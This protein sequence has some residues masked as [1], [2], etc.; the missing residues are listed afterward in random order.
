MPARR[1]RSASARAYNSYTPLQ[2]AQAMATL[3]TAARCTSRAWSRR[4]TTRAPG[5]RVVDREVNTRV[6]FRPEHVDFIKRAMAGV[7]KEGTGARAFAGAQY[8]SAARPAP[9]R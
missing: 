8:S 1:S 5:A 9:R 4:S 6:R 3:S 7:N 2:L